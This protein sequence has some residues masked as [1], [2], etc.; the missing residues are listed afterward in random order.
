MCYLKNKKGEQLF[1]YI[2]TN[3]KE[4]NRPSVSLLTWE[5]AIKKLKSYAQDFDNPTWYRKVIS[6]SIDEE[7]HDATAELVVNH[8]G[9]GYNYFECITI[10]RVFE[11]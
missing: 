9:W 11:P 6:L 4:F 7:R 10:D 8:K 5:D 3:S 1:H 2:H